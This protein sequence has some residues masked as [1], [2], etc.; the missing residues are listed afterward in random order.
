M[1]QRRFALSALASL[2]IIAACSAKTLPERG[3]LVVQISTDGT[4]SPDVIKLQVSNDK[5]I[6][7]QNEFLL[8]G[9]TLPNTISIVSNG[10]PTATTKI[11]V[12]AWLEGA[13]L[14]RRDAIVLQVPTDRVAFLPIQLSGKC[15]HLVEL[16][17]DGSVNSTC[18]DQKTCDANTGECTS[19]VYD[20][21]DLPDYDDPNK[22][23]R[24]GGT[25][26]CA[27]GNCLEDGAT[28]S[29]ANLDGGKPLDKPPFDWV[30]IIG[31]GQSNAVGV[32]ATSLIST[33]QPFNNGKLV[34]NGPDPKYPLSGGTP[35]YSIVPLTEK[36]RETSAGS[37]P[38]YTDSSY[39]NNLV[40]ETPHSGMANE[41]TTLFKKRTSLDYLTLH[42]AVGWS[43]RPLAM[44]DKASGSRSYNAG[45]A[46]ARAFKTLAAAAGKTFGYGAVVLTHGESD[47]ISSNGEYAAAL[48]VFIDDY[49]TD[50]KAITGQ[51][52]D[53]P[54]L[55]TQQSA[56]AVLGSSAI[57][58]WNAA[59]AYPQ[60]IV[61]VGPKYQYAYSPDGL[62]FPAP[63]HRRMGEKY[64]EVF[65]L[66][67]NQNKVWKPVQPKSAARLGSSIVVEFDVPN[68]PL[69][70]DTTLPLPHQSTNTSWAKGRGFEVRDSTNAALA[71]SDV[72]IS[73]PTSVTITLSKTVPAGVT[74][75]YATVADSASGNH[76]GAADGFI[77]Q[78]R[79]SD[80]LV[81][82][83]EEAINLEV[84]TG[85]ATATF[86]GGA[87]NRNHGVRDVVTG[88]NAPANWTIT[89]ASAIGPN[90]V[91]TM[92]SP[93]TGP[94]GTSLLAVHHDL[95]NYAV[96]SSLGAN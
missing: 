94:T 1:I 20:A 49:N 60:R 28:S 66:V 52:R 14:D 4:I 68:P 34:D 77:G 50:L 73:S 10:D 48:K 27:S 12:S 22:P 57:Q 32:T 25:D 65:D 39:P 30:G 89:S 3:G 19:A 93:W 6:L 9:T 85:S 51:T 95:H 83:D 54:M 44:I 69:E 43:G 91:F 75:S 40:G 46:E 24:D 84:V 13:P 36:I 18:G 78:L 61:C 59:L 74:V 71:I 70:W 92:S 81:G 96:H 45:L 38:G 47:A 63:G 87:A 5:K 33:V 72:T 37:G 67:V 7:F 16:T 90:A 62:H 64:A 82:Y 86:T 76:G 2:G 55:L 88:T 42:S 58:S 35:N 80:T 79:D 26:A 11:V 15:T 23:S 8:P 31:T 21:H 29:D 41:I 53:I 56:T 17:T